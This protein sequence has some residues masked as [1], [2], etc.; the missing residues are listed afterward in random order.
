VIDHRTCERDNSCAPDD[1]D[2]IVGTF[3][4]RDRA[5]S[6]DAGG[7]APGWSSRWTWSTG[8]AR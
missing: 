5:I 8:R 2:Q 4:G 1:G 7:R 3:S 6:A